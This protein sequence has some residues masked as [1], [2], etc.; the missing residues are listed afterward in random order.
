MSI[1]QKW[2]IKQINEFVLDPDRGTGHGISLGMFFGVLFLP[3]AALGLA[4]ALI[5]MAINHIRVA[6]QELFIEGWKDKKKEPDFY[7]D[8]FFRPLQTD[9]VL[10]F[11]LTPHCYWGIVTVLALVVG[12]K[13]K[14]QWPLLLGFWR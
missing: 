12:F 13:M 2:P 1:D 9:V 6:Y 11:A 4:P 3:V 5:I 10:L 8:C 14:N 7:Y